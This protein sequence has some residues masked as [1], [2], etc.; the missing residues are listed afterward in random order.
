MFED[1]TELEWAYLAGRIDAD[2]SIGCYK[3]NPKWTMVRLDLYS[4]DK[5]FLE[6]VQSLLGGYV[7]INSTTWQWNAGTPNVAT[8]LRRLLPYLKTK[9]DQAE[10]AI[11]CREHG[12]KTSEDHVFYHTESKR[13]NGRLSYATRIN[14]S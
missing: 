14:Q 2:G 1:V 3:H 8:I 10:L 9:K 11:K 12:K 5:S 7:S 4:N 6:W 13:L